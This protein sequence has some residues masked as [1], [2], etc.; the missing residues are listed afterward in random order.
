MSSIEC[1]E[2]DAS[3]YEFEKTDDKITKLMAERDRLNSLNRDLTLDYDVTKR[4]LKLRSVFLTEKKASLKNRLNSV[5]Q[6]MVESE[7]GDE[8]LSKANAE[9]ANASKLVERVKSELEKIY[10]DLADTVSSLYDFSTPEDNSGLVRKVNL[11]K[12]SIAH[13]KKKL[14]SAKSENKELNDKLELLNQN[15]EILMN[16]RND[17]SS[18]AALAEEKR[19]ASLQILAEPIDDMSYEESVVKTL[20]TDIQS[21]EEKSELMNNE[22]DGCDDSCLSMA[23]LNTHRKRVLLAKKQALMKQRAIYEN[24]ERDYEI[25]KARKVT[26]GTDQVETAHVQTKLDDMAAK[27]SRMQND[28]NTKETETDRMCDENMAVRRKMIDEW[29]KKTNRIEELTSQLKENA[30]LSDDILHMNEQN[31]DAKERLR[32]LDHRIAELHRRIANFERDRTRN[33]QTNSNIARH[34]AALQLKQQAVHEKDE[35][36]ALRREELALEEQ[37]LEALQEKV[38]ARE[39]EIVLLEDK[40]KEIGAKMELTVQTFHKEKEQFDELLRSI[41]MEQQDQFTGLVE[42]LSE[43][44]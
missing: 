14:E 6:Q 35:E 20:E 24:Q 17:F 32:S 36:L 42:F 33:N 25:K 16:M 39:N 26:L 7:A 41:P 21:L 10:S 4:Q 23:S 31:A 40:V 9:H 18:K 27:L 34:K 15:E 12:T 22:I 1:E 28:I 37:P 11:L 29:T 8:A 3:S 30:K 2:I 13:R 43:M 38:N 5:R 19:L 44:K